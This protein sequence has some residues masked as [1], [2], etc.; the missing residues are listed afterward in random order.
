MY[1]LICILGYKVLDIDK[2]VM[3]TLFIVI[4]HEVLD[5][6]SKLREIRQRLKVSQEYMARSTGL[7]LQTYRNAELGGNV[8]YTTATTILDALNRELMGRGQ[9]TLDLSA[10]GLSIV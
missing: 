8:T 10:L 3:Y 1:S 9:G 7:S 4:V 2:L 5:M 6:S